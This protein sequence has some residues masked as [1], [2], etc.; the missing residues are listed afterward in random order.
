MNQSEL[1]PWN[2]IESTGLLVVIQNTHMVIMSD[3]PQGVIGIT[4]YGAVI[5]I[6]TN[7]NLPSIAIGIHPGNIERL[8][9]N[10]PGG[11]EG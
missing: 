6:R 7:G 10:Q 3:K 4:Q 2:H 9:Q 1:S 5:Q 8:P 11:E